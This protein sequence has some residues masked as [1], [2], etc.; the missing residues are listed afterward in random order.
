MLLTRQSLRPGGKIPPF[1]KTGPSVVD[2]FWVRSIIAY[3][4][5]AGASMLFK[6][7]I[8]SCLACTLGALLLVTLPGCSACRTQ[9]DHELQDRSPPAG[10]IHDQ[11]GR[12]TVQ[13]PDQLSLTIP[14]RPEWSGLREIDVDGRIPLDQHTRLRVAG[15]IPPEIAEAVARKAG[16]PPQEVQVR[17]EAFN[18]QQL[19]LFGEVTGLPRAVPYR[20]PERVVDLLRRVGGITPGA[21]HHNVRVVRAHVADGKTPEVFQV[22]LKAILV[23]KEQETN[24]ILQ[25]FDR[26]YIGQTRRSVIACCFPPWLQKLV[27][28]GVK[29]ARRKPQP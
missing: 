4:E 28:I 19:F 9:I 13:C 16:S 8:F 6:E 24:L 1:L 12:Y 17:V 27:Q 3:L 5:R 7:G 21:S 25:P 29:I 2:V 20:G 22:D 11:I 15:L 10:R 18:S 14:G 23:D 26:V